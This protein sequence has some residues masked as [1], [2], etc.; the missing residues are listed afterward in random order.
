MLRELVVSVAA[1]AVC[2]LLGAAIYEA[3]VM[4]PN[5]ELGT[6]A[7][8]HARGFLVVSTPAA[9]FRVLA[10]TVQIL[11]ALSIVLTW[12]TL[13][14]RRRLLLF[15]ALG[16][17]IAADVVTFAF[18]YPRNAVLFVAPL[19]RSSA[20]LQRIAREWAWGNDVRILLLVG[21]AVAAFSAVHCVARRPGP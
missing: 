6:Q 12:R 10:P 3:V 11:L 4:A 17:A 20:E 7:L 16:A 13:A 18:H 9:F 19:D 2:M 21:A 15:A 8:E 1:A 14:G 5:F